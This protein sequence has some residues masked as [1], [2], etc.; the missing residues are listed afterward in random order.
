MKKYSNTKSESFLDINES[1]NDIKSV[2]KVALENMYMFG[3]MPKPDPM[4]DDYLKGMIDMIMN[5]V[6]KTY[7]D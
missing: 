5:A 3:G 4:Y 6:K 7:K 2:A 1:K